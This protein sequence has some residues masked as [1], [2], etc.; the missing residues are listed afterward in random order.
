MLIAKISEDVLDIEEALTRVLWDGFVK[1]FE[2]SSR[3][4]PRENEC[5]D[6]GVLRGNMLSMRT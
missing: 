5:L 3:H 1:E 2:G 4:A 6:E